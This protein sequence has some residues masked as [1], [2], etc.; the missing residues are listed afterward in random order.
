MGVTKIREMAVEFFGAGNT[1]EFEQKD[2]FNPE[3]VVRGFISRRPT[4]FYGALLIGWVNGK[5]CPQPQLIYATPKM[6]YPFDKPSD[7]P[8]AQRRWR[9]PKAQKIEV[10][11]K[12]DGTNI[13]AYE[14]RDAAGRSFI[15]YKVRLRPFVQNSKWGEFQDMWFDMLKCYPQI[16]SVVRKNQCAVSFELY[17]G[18]NDKMTI[19]YDLPLSIA[20]LFGVKDGSILAPSQLDTLELPTSPLEQIVTHDYV[21]TYQEIQQ[22]KDD[23]LVVLGGG[24]F[25]GDEG[26]MWYL[27]TPEG[28][29]LQ[30]KCKPPSIEETH[31]AMGSHSMNRNNV[32]TTCWNVFESFDELN[33]DNL[34]ALLREEWPDI[35]IEKNGELI[36]RAISH[37]NDEAE[38][39]ARVLDTYGE[40]DEA[41]KTDIPT[42]MRALSPHFL[43]IE[44]GRVYAVVSTCI[45]T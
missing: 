30:Y 1:D 37:V 18:P 19:Q 11:T 33:Y 44:M 3:N 45:T 41:V 34:L 31:W 10:Y 39:R 23:Q 12:I 5:E 9:F 42:I 16:P 7:K 8:D 22:K 43:R 21:W 20:L 36:E 38:F 14:Y 29:V 28:K 27:F 17:G 4:K 35:E 2:P 40:L 32:I 25:K 15:T 26:A 6:H 24:R 13:L